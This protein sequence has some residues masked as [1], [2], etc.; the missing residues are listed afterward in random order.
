MKGSL[1]LTAILL[2]LFSF[3]IVNETNAQIS[4]QKVSQ[5]VEGYQFT[6][7][8]SLDTSAA[9]TGDYDS[10]WT[11][12]LGLAGFDNSEQYSYHSYVHPASGV[13]SYSVEVFYSADNITYTKVDTLIYQS[14]NTGHLWGST[15]VQNNTN[16]KNRAPYVKLL[17]LRVAKAGTDVVA[18]FRFD[19]II[20]EADPA[21]KP[22]TITGR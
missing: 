18:P 15:K 20:P 5:S 16:Q 19:L 9:A 3:F 8:G 12:E 13:L 11:R 2:I 6:A 7:I 17:L 14:S 21:Y 4:S 1:A 10:L 22:N